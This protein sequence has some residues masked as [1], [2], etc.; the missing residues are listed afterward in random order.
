MNKRMLLTLTAATAVVTTAIMSA[1]PAGADPALGTSYAAAVKISTGSGMAVDVST[2]GDIGGLLDFLTPV[3]DQVVT[4][5]TSAVTALPGTLVSDLVGGLSGTG[6]VANSTSSS[7][8]PPGSGFPTCTSGGWSTDN[9]YSVA[10][11][12]VPAA[13]VLNLTTGALQGYAAA[14]SSGAY[15]SA[16][17]AGVSL[18]LLGVNIGTLGVVSSTSQCLASTACSS[19]SSIT[20]VSL[21]NGTVAVK[22]ASDGSL[23]VSVNGGGYASLAAL[24]QSTVSAAG[25][26]AIVGPSNGYLKVAISLSLDQL[27]TGLGISD[28][29]SSLNASD[30]GSQITLTL[31]LGGRQDSASETRAWGLRLGV[32]LTAD[33]G[34][35]VLGL[36]SAAVSVTDSSAT[37]DLVDLQLAYTSAANA[38]GS[39]NPSGAPPALT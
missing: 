25:L 22:S 21:L 4:P 29:L 38:D 24:G 26:S 6:L 8:S 7:Q 5:L 32:G 23:L 36:V 31:M 20:G 16:Q 1:V 37:G 18:S 3:L 2:G 33:I 15:A 14:D 17:T 34:I 13:P 30:S 9:C 11:V 39:S 35:S 27:L 28:V 10:S 12:P 19:G